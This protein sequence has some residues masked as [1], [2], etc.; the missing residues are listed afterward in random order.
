MPVAFILIVG[1]VVGGISLLFGLKWL[2]A[3]EESRKAKLARERMQAVRVKV[4]DE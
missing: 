2:A 3:A 1:I 4:E